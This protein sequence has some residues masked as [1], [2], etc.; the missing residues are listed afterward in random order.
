M[1]VSEASLER[2]EEQR[3]RL[4]ELRGFL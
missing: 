2:L 3:S 4:D 1:A